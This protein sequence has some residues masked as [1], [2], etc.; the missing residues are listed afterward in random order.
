MTPEL[1]ARP[2]RPAGSGE[3]GQA[4]ATAITVAATA[5]GVMVVFLVNLLSGALPLKLLDPQWQIKVILLLIANVTFP[6]VAFMLICLAPELD[7]S[8][9]S[10]RRWRRRC[11]SMAV[12]AV[13]LLLLILPLQSSATWRLIRQAE[14][15]QAQQLRLDQ[16]RYRALQEAIQGASTQADLQ[17][18][19]QILEGPL[20]G[21]EDRNRPLA[22]VRRSLLQ[23]LETAR[24]SNRLQRTALPAEQVGALLANTLQICVTSLALAACFAAGARRPG[25]RH[26]LLQELRQ[27]LH[28]VGALGHRLDSDRNLESRF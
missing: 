28:R 8:V 24:A 4:R 12:A 15:G 3:R 1:H 17:R 21:R 11:Q 20:L 6:L 22:E 16:R 26:S 18:R 25:S 13:L 2:W 10:L 9:L 14:A 5:V 23:A 19:L 7:P 27:L